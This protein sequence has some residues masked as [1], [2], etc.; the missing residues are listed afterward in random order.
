M[1]ILFTVLAVA[2]LLGCAMPPQSASSPQDHAAAV[3]YKTDQYTKITTISGGDIRNGSNSIRLRAARSIARTDVEP[4]IGVYATMFY[5]GDWRFYDSAYT[6]DGRS[7]ETQSLKRDVL[8]C[9]RN[10]CQHGE[11]VLI[12]FPADYLRE[13]MGQ[14]IDLKIRGVGGE[15]TFFIP[16]EYISAFLAGVFNDPRAIR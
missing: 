9:S 12:N 7:W 11:L 6:I 10:R 4:A 3:T 16:P 1:K 15:E 2:G 8:G 13:K 14:G 5:S